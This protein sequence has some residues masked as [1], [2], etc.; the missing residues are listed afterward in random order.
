MIN[1]RR[2]VNHLKWKRFSWMGHSM[3]AGLG[4]Y[5]ASLFPAEVG[6]IFI[7]QGN[8]RI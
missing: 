3:G 5:Y 7:K 2:I 4:A 8:S 6:K 1:L